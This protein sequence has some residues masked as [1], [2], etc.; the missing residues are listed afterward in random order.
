M[1][2]EPAK[3]AESSNDALTDWASLWGLK[4]TYQTHEKIKKQDSS[5][6]YIASY[7]KR[8]RASQYLVE[9]QTWKSVE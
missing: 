6:F 3:D 5:K 1:G 7:K 2:L 9:E 4:K 8:V